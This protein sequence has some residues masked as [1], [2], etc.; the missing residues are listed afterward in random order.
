M[1][2]SLAFLIA[3]VVIVLAFVF[4]SYVVFMQFRPEREIRSMM[5]TMMQLTSV[6]QESGF[7]WTQQVDGNRVSTTLYASGPLELT[8]ERQVNH[9]TKFRVVHLSHGDT[10]QDLSGELRSISG[11][12]YLTYTAPG[13]DVPGVDFEEP[14]WVEFEEGELPAWGSIIPG[15]HPPMES[16]L[17]P[18]AWTPE[19][20][21]R[22][23]Y[24]LSYADLFHVEYNGLTEL[25]GGV[26]TRI[27]D[28]RFDQDAIQAFLLDLVRAKEGR[29]PNDDERI[30]AGAQAKQLSRLTLRFWI[31]IPD[32]RLYRIQAAGGF[33]DLEGTDLLPVD[34]R[35]EFQSFQE[36]VEIEIPDERIHFQEIFRAVLGVLPSAG[37]TS[38]TKV[39]TLV[40]EQSARLPVTETESNDDSDGDGLDS[41]LEAFYGTDPENADTDGDG[42]NDGDE[43]RS[44]RNPRG[45][46]S[47]F[48]FGL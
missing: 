38:N 12:S 47:L 20:L 7:S 14:T 26:N 22:L 1:K 44:G 3:G 19:G 2:K 43:V 24:L 16:I 34:V 33:E 45:S 29:H 9:A 5:M 21:E 6:E 10:Y 35:I 15:L 41:I 46:G 25:I 13:P 17:S 31:G 18:Q 32:H 30:L 40:D 36:E 42:M 48:G 37:F 11:K 39:L 8:P 27:I 4:A 28:G 23:Q